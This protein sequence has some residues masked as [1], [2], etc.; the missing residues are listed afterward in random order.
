MALSDL[1]TNVQLLLRW[2]HVLAGIIWIGHL[3]FFNFINGAFLGSLPAD[4]K[5]VVVPQLM[6]RVLFWFRWGAMFTLLAGL[7]LFTQIYM[8]TPGLGFGP[9]EVFSGADGMTGRAIWILFGMVL[10]I[11]MWFNVWFIIWPAQQ[12]IIRGVRDGKPADPA[13]PKRAALASRINTV[14]SGPMLFGM[15]AATHYGGFNLVSA[16][17]ATVLGAAAL[18]HFIAL[19]PKVGK[20]I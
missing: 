20:S 6:P 14:L 16:L 19:G 5:K 10:G 3:Y 4:V 1:Y 9:S 18:W 12:K 17:V 13:L 11:V 8:Y 15:L 2:I 7:A